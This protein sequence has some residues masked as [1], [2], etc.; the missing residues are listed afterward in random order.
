MDLASPIP[1]FLSG[2]V[3]I[4]HDSFRSHAAPSST[5]QLTAHDI[6]THRIVR[7]DRNLVTSAKS[8]KAR[9]L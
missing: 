2:E 8:H 5:H 4:L 3:L 1:Q 9:L 6:Q 7:R